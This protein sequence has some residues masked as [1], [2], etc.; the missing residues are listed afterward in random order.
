MVVHMGSPSDTFFY[1]R[2][3]GRGCR[4]HPF[5]AL[6]PL[7]A[8]STMVSEWMVSSWNGRSTEP[9]FVLANESV[10]NSNRLKFL[11]YAELLKIV[12]R[13][14][15]GKKYGKSNKLSH[16]LKN[17][18]K[19]LRKQLC[20]RNPPRPT[21]IPLNWATFL[22]LITTKET[23]EGGLQEKAVQFQTGNL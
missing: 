19:M 21:V 13:N 9:D 20:L 22:D 17:R 1:Q 7:P 12:Q 5:H 23:K 3:N 15:N 4:T 14:L 6:H 10:C 8:L 11:L 18:G 16:H 2:S